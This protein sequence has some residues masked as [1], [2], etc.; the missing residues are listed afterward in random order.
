MKNYRWALNTAER[1]AEVRARGW[2]PC[3]DP[4][5]IDQMVVRTGYKPDNMVLVE[6]E[7]SE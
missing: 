3:N 7:K 5:V 2:L 1:L 6:R 4:D